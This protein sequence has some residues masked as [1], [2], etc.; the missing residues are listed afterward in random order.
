MMNE[1]YQRGPIS[2]EIGLTEG[3]EE[4]KSGIF[5]DQTGKKGFDHDIVVTGWGE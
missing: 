1:I 5:I 3:L 2:C 4:Y